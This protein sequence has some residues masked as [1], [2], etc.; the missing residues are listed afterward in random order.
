MAT[1][2]ENLKKH[3]EMALGQLKQIKV[4]KKKFDVKEL[5]GLESQITNLIT[6]LNDAA[7]EEALQGS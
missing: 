6:E 3:L 4:E 5:I 1:A 2:Y 7:E